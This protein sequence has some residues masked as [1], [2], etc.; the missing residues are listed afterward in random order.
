MKKL[1]IIILL[2]ITLT[3]C[4]NSKRING[5]SIEPYGLFNQEL[6]RDDVVYNLSIGTIIL[7]VIFV[8]TLI[9][10]VIA[11]GWYLWEPQR[12]KTVLSVNPKTRKK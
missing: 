6:K 12:Q 5:E 9:V 11:C 3:S 1:L 10:P 4:A 8:E 2:S 7:S